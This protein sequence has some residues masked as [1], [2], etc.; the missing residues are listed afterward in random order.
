MQK[1]ILNKIYLLEKVEL[2][3]LSFL[4]DNKLNLL[5]QLCGGQLSDQSIEYLHQLELN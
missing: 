4:L 2:K 5:D 3:N 1:N